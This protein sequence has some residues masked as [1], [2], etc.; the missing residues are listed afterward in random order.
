MES[1]QAVDCN[2][3]ENSP[4]NDVNANITE[5]NPSFTTIGETVGSDDTGL[6]EIESL[7]MNCHENGL[8]KLMMTNIPYFREIILMSFECEHCN[9]SNN[10]VQFGGSIMERG[11]KYT[12]IVTKEEDLN[13]QLIKSD[14][15]S[16]RLPAIDF[17]IPP[18][19]QRGG[20]STVE[21][22]LTTAAKQ[23]ALEQA[24]RMEAAPEV[25]SAVAEII[26][27][28][29][30]FANGME[31]PF[32]IE[33]DDPAGNSFLENPFAPQTDPNMTIKH[34]ER[35]PTQDLAV[36]LQPTETAKEDGYIDDQNPQH[37]SVK[38]Q[39]VEGA[40]GLLFDS[41]KDI[42][43]K[44]VIAFPEDCPHCHTRGESNM[45][46]TDIPHFKEII[47]MAFNCQ[48]C[49]F[50]SNEI[51]GG[52]AIPDKGTQ[53][54]LRVESEEDMARDILK[55]DS[56]GIA[57]PE[58]ELEVE[59]GSLG[60]MYTTL[61]GL[62]DKIRNKLKE[63]NPFYSGDSST[64]QHDNGGYMSTTKAK[65]DEFMRKLDELVDKQ[66]FPFTLIL[67]DPLGNSFIGSQM[68]N[69]LEDPQ[70]E[71]A[72]YERSFEENETLGL[73]D[74]NVDNYT[75]AADTSVGQDET[76]QE[77][78]LPDRITHAH[79]RGPDHPHQF[80]KGCEDEETVT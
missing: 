61:E 39:T 27:K 11:C 50:K 80:T 12:L 26:V 20:I 60:G 65:F 6:N 56:A 51:K 73:N 18:K 9:F 69:F 53:M 30:S 62:L 16:V 14:F 70:I 45:C 36:G 48:E 7:C 21:G 44:E 37:K 66:I 55:S 59:A 42:G 22:I 57:I 23:L 34:Y 43:R 47:I 31:L 67:K 75:L 10:E 74:I 38:G 32:T 78:I 54:T 3:S 46:V 68:E 19:T 40:E 28:L 2:S 8:T 4:N 24:Y 77:P 58:I 35:T 33:V 41:S 1:S 52:G 5:A 25:G 64:Q 15:A 49:G 71:S 17:E 79:I 63:G 29:S 13:R 72:D 76:R